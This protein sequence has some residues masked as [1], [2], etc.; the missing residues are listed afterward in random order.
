MTKVYDIFSKLLLEARWRDVA[1]KYRA[2]WDGKSDGYQIHNIDDYDSLVQYFMDN[3]PSGSNKYLEYLLN[4][5]LSTKWNVNP[6]QLVSNVGTFHRYAERGFIENKDLYS[7]HYRPTDEN[8]V[9]NLYDAIGH[10]KNKEEA[11]EKQKRLDKA[12]RAEGDIIFEDSR[13]RVVIPKTHRASCHY[14]IG[15]KWCTT[16]KN[17]PSHFNSYTKN[18][19][20]FYIL[21]KSSTKSN[22]MYKFAMLWNWGKANDGTY[23]PQDINKARGFDSGD[24][25]VKMSHVLPFMPKDMIEAITNSYN[26]IVKDKNP[27]A[28][29]TKHPDHFLA[30]LADY[31]Y[32]ETF[33]DNLSNDLDT[34]LHHLIEPFGGKYNM[35]HTSD[36]SISFWVAE[37][38][39]DEEPIGNKIFQFDLPSSDTGDLVTFNIYSFQKFGEDSDDGDFTSSYYDSVALT[40]YFISTF[41]RQFNYSNDDLQFI[42]D[43]SDPGYEL[44]DTV[45]QD[46]RNYAYA[47]TVSKFMPL[48]TRVLWK[49]DEVPKTDNIIYWEPQNSSSR[50][51]LKYPPQRNSVTEKFIEVLHKNPGITINDFYEMTQGRSRPAGHNSQLF[52]SIRDSGIVSRERGPKGFK[53]SIG[54]NYE[55]WTQGRLKRY[56]GNHTHSYEL[57]NTLLKRR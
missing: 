22:V 16:A 51:K 40:S 26:K 46:L 44:G 33:W 2:K 14:G 12:M 31:G 20:L 24:S 32:Y 37:K 36:D 8:L 50:V 11:K 49:D 19:V 38:M 47:Y 1:E 48:I 41:M 54:P 56:E 43:G 39:G 53:Y 13:W 35:E 4:V 28:D 17:T 55:A 7:K 25:P 23:V 6:I 21:D 18:G 30:A 27:K 29:V 52:G 15:T 10:A 3:D 57:M 42:I 34:R 45:I 5:S 9:G